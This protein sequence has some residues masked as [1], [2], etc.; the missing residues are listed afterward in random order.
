MSILKYIISGLELPPKPGQMLLEDTGICT[1]KRT[2]EDGAE[3]VVKLPQAL[4]GNADR[5]RRR[6]EGFFARALAGNTALW[7]TR[8]QT[9]SSPDL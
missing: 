6:R 8:F 1:R 3:D 2:P 4:E 5:T 9:S 7:R